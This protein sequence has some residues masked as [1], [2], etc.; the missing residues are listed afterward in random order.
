VTH[1]TAA[2]PTRETAHHRRF[3]ERSDVLQLLAMVRRSSNVSSPSSC[4]SFQ[5]KHKATCRGGGCL[6]RHSHYVRVRLGGI[7]IWRMQYHVSPQCS[8]SCPTLSCAIVTCVRRSPATPLG[9]PWRTE[10]R[11]VRG[12]VLHFADGALSPGLCIR[13]PES[14]DNAHPVWPALA[15]LLL[16]RREAQP[17]SDRQS[18]SADDCVWPGH[19]AP[20]LHRGFCISPNKVYSSSICY[21]SCPIGIR[22]SMTTVD[23]FDSSRQTL[24]GCGQKRGQERVYEHRTEGNENLH[25]AGTC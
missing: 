17:Q 1:G 23:R 11:A 14:G 18:L 24:Y 3:P 7:T 8:R 15:H 25:K 9:H 13:A 2:Q 20:G 22:S 12:D 10:F 19:L 6:T 21:A 5:L 4:P 16:G